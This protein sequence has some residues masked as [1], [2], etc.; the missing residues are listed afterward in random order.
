MDAQAI[1]KRA[2]NLMHQA[3]MRR[4][5]AVHSLSFRQAFEVQPFCNACVQQCLRDVHNHCCKPAL[6]PR[7]TG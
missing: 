2:A 1:L 7:A 6:V 5:S 4:A 3:R